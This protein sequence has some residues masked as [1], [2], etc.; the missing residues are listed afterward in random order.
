MSAVAPAAHATEVQYASLAQQRA[1]A[2]LGMWIF[3]ATEVLF[4]GGLFFVYAYCAS[5]SPTLRRREPAHDVV[6]G[7][8]NTAVLLTSSLTMALAVRAAERCGAGS[9]CCCCC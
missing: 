3:L 4:F 2:T 9:P 8:T 6:L 7:T 5:A 1:A